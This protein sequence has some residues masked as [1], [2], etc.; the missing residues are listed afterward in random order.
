MAKATIKARNE[1]FK[2]IE[3]VKF[4][5]SIGL[6]NSKL[7]IAAKEFDDEG[8]IKLHNNICQRLFK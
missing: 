8:L 6:T 4:G 5:E 3:M 7:I 1:L 2:I